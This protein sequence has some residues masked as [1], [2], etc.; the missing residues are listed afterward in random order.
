MFQLLIIVG[1]VVIEFCV[2]KNIL[3]VNV[4][5]YQGFS[6]RFFSPSN[7]SIS[8][9]SVIFW[10]LASPIFSSLAYIFTLF[11]NSTRECNYIQFDMLWLISV[12]FWLWFSLLVF[13]LGR[14]KLVNWLFV[15]FIAGSS[16]LFNWYLSSISFTGDVKD[17]LPNANNTTF[18][19]YLIL[20]IF[21]VSTIQIIYERDDYDLRRTRFILEKLDLYLSKFKVLFELE[22]EELYL[23]LA[24]LIVEDFERP[25]FIRYIENIIKSSTRNIAQNDSRNDNHSVSL[26]V[27]EIHDLYIIGEDDYPYQRIRNFA[28][29]YN[30]SSRYAD[31]V[32][33]IYNEVSKLDENIKLLKKTNHNV[34]E[35]LI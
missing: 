7:N 12:L 29:K 17:I 33:K 4:K 10:I 19:L 25:K 1:I 5:D 23:A 32:W 16:I 3:S 35:E 11:V 6:T 24:I 21:L 28:L 13:V 27:K 20:G 15:S 14:R 34:S 18:Q 8:T 31:D 2:L 9:G 22:G 26:L 30:N